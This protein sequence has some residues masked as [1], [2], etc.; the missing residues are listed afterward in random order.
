M[1]TADDQGDAPP[2][3]VLP[4]YQEK[5]KKAIKESKHSGTRRAGAELITDPPESDQQKGKDAADK[6][7]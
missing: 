1:E 7:G 2:D 4:E 6:P 5:V 3:G